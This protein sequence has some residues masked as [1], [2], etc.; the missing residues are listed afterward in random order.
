MGTSGDSAFDELQDMMAAV[1]REG[2][3]RS[4]ALALPAFGK[5]GTSQD[6]RDALFIGFA[7]DLVVGVWVGNDD[8]SPLGSAVGGGGLPARIWRDFMSQALGAAPARPAAAPAQAPVET[9]SDANASLVVPI[10]GTDYEFGIELANDSVI[11]SA[12]PRPAE[13]DEPAPSQDPT[14]PIAAPPPKE[15]PAPEEDGG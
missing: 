9:I 14:P 12:E 2:T 5:T 3:G 10:E 11:L 1:V 13:E 4:A 15:E 8:N 6:S 7:E